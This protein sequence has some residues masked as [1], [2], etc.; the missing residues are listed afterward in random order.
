MGASIASTS[1]T[2][3]LSGRCLLPLPLSR[4]LGAYREPTTASS[5][6]RAMWTAPT[7]TWGYSPCT[8]RQKA[9]QSGNAAFQNSQR[10]LAQQWP[11]V[12]TRPLSSSP[13]GRTLAWLCQ[14]VPSWTWTLLIRMMPAERSGIPPRRWQ[15]MQKMAIPSGN[16]NSPTGTGQQPVTRPLIP[17]CRTPMQTLPSLEMALFFWPVCPAPSTA[18][19]TRMGT[20]SLIQPV[21]RSQRMTPGMHSRPLQQSVRAFLQC[22]PAMA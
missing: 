9:S 16:T 4:P 20:V 6:S 12:G 13:L 2:G 17:A 8:L 14:W 3:L 1:R 15:W 10:T 18:F 5:T 7:D 22:L 11:Q 21:V 19:S